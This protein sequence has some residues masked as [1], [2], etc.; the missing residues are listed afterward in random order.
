MTLQVF[1]VWLVEFVTTLIWQSPIHC[2][3]LK[4][5]H[6][7]NWLF[8]KPCFVGPC[9]CRINVIPTFQ[10]Q[11]ITKRN[12]NKMQSVLMLPRNMKITELECN[13]NIIRVDHVAATIMVDLEWI[14][15]NRNAL[16]GVKHATHVASRTTFQRSSGQRVKIN[17]VPYSVSRITELLWISSVRM[18]YLTQQLMHISWAIA[19]AVKR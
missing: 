16:H 5:K 2:I 9:N 15:D 6:D 10:C 12:E 13:P 3:G 8:L 7:L 17:E 4:P 1:N 19:T 14:I 18:W 11:H